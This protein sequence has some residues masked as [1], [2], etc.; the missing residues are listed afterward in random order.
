MHK[1][2][3]ITNDLVLRR[4]RDG[5]YY[6]VVAVGAPVVGSQVGI[7]RVGGKRTWWIQTHRIYREFGVALT[8]PKAT[9]T[10]K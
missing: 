7:R 2:T 9:E 8:Q 1:P 5:A 4:I 3:A 10:P 6:R